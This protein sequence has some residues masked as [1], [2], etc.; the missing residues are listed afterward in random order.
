MVWAQGNGLVMHVARAP[1]ERAYTF[2]T[3]AHAK[4]RQ[5]LN[6]VERTF[7]QVSRRLAD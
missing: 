6:N 5:T 7:A 2:F 3:H 1:D 4:R